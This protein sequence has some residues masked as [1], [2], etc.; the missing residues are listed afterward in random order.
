M[1]RRTP[2]RVH[3]IPM[4]RKLTL[5]LVLILGLATVSACVDATGPPEG[6]PPGGIVPAPTGQSV[7]SI[8]YLPSPDTVLEAFF[9]DEA[10]LASADAAALRPDLA[11]AASAPFA[12]ARAALAAG[13]SV[14]AREVSGAGRTAVGSVLFGEDGDDALRRLD[15]RVGLL[16]ERLGRSSDEFAQLSALVLLLD[17][18][19]AGARL[20]AES[21][22]HP[23]AIARYILALT[24]ATQARLAYARGAEDVEA[25]AAKALVRGTMAIELAE[26]RLLDRSS[27]EGIR[28]LRYAQSQILDARRSHA[29]GR[30]GRA[31]IEAARAESLSLMAVIDWERPSRVDAQSLGAWTAAL[32]H[33]RESA[34]GQ[35]PPEALVRA[36]ARAE[37]LTVTAERL[38][39]VSEW[40]GASLFWEAA[41]TARTGAA[42]R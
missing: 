41:V 37:S 40:R 25:V 16:I 2:L 22:R 30:L 26:E 23:E 33:E 42:R 12:L 13:D 24:S 36:L 7:E 8:E 39:D 9:V 20:L 18:T 4:F 21:D 34:A 38:I 10:A 29:A 14:A 32:I 5:I 28:A 15:T 31:A 6:D 35:F 19:H 17:F 27:T 1:W 3:H 11:L